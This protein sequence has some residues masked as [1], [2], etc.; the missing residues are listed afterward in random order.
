MTTTFEAPKFVKPDIAT[1]SNLN[2]WDVYIG[3]LK[4]GTML[5]QKDKIYLNVFY[6]EYEFKATER[7]RITLSIQLEYARVMLHITSAKK[8]YPTKKLREYSQFKTEQ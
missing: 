1:I 6:N 4:I 2:F 8:E 7:E 3:G 5:K